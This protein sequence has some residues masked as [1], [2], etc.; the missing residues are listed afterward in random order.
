MYFCR[1]G[2]CSELMTGMG[3]VRIKKSVTRL[4][5]AIMYQTVVMLMHLPGMDES[6]KVATGWQMSVNKKARATAQ[7]ARKHSA[8][9]VMR[10]MMALANRRLY[11]SRMDILV[12][13]TATL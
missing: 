6:Q 5:P 2:S 9:S 8:V 7:A 1:L 4:T 11:W 12:R 13:H 10:W 3:S